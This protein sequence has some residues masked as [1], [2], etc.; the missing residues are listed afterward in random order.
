MVEKST[1][2]N[3]YDNETIT[4][5]DNLGVNGTTNEKGFIADK[6]SKETQSDDESKQSIVQKTHDDATAGDDDEATLQKN[7]ND[8]ENVEE[9]IN[10][11]RESR[12][13]N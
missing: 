3:D 11:K 13:W 8:K 6:D 7:T 5:N 2:G 10:D 1:K 9:K 4:E 12:Q